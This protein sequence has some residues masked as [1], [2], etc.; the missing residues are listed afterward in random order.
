MNEMQEKF[1]GIW[2]SDI[3]EAMTKGRWGGSPRSAQ[4]TGDPINDLMC[5]TT[6]STKFGRR[7]LLYAGKAETGLLE[8]GRQ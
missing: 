5:N 7:P 1:S 3:S 6:Q 2:G 4:T 8:D